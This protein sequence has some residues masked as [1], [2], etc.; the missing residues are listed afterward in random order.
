MATLERLKFKYLVCLNDNLDSPL[1]IKERAEHI[2]KRLA[3]DVV[4]YCARKQGNPFTQDEVRALLQ[5]SGQ[6]HQQAQGK[7]L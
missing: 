6:L 3:K 4:V 2:A 1:A 7:Y 5:R